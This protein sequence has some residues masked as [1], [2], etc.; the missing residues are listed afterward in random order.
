MNNPLGRTWS[1]NEAIQ[2]L[3][4]NYTRIGHPIAFSNAKTI[5]DFFKKAIPVKEIKQFLS[6]VNTY[7]LHR[8]NR[9]KASAYIPMFAFKARDLVEI[10]LIDMQFFSPKQNDHVRYL[11]LAIDTFTKA[12]FIEPLVNKKSDAVLEAF[13]KIH[14]RMTSDGN[15]IR[16]ICS[17]LGA[18][19]INRKF[20]SYLNEWMTN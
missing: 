6:S 1:K 9:K 5:Y 3:K 7:T 8:E 15:R 10:D 2:E 17:D 4:T 11:L 13:R 12:I 20:R 16:A 19:F 14:H 18:E